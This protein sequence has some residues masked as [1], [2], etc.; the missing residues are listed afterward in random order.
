MIWIKLILTDSSRLAEKKGDDPLSE[1]SPWDIF[2]D[3]SQE[4]KN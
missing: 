2:I 1:S 3:G 4:R